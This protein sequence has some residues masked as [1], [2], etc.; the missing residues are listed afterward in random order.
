MVYRTMSALLAA[1]RGDTAAATRVLGEAPAHEPGPH[2]AARARIAAILGDADR[3]LALLTEALDHFPQR[4]RIVGSTS[5]TV[6]AQS[7]QTVRSVG[8]RFGQSRWS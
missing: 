4:E 8:Y 7:I 5:S 6:G 2:L 3:A 1:R